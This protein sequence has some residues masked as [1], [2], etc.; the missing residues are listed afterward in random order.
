MIIKTNIGSFRVAVGNY[1]QCRIYFKDEEYFGLISEQKKTIL[2]FSPQPQ[3]NENGKYV[4]GINVEKQ[5]DE[6]KKEMKKKHHPKN[7]IFLR[8]IPQTTG[9]YELSER[10][11]H[12]KWSKIAH[13]MDKI[14]IYTGGE[15]NEDSGESEGFTTCWVVQ[16]G[17]ETEV[18]HI[19]KI[20][21][22]I[23]KRKEVYWDY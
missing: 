11:D 21:D 14:E 7:P 8:K 23:K 18:E 20:D 13:I 1:H 12:K 2:F 16:K 19:L 5:W 22:T 9:M 4:G 6:M 3:I 17:R 15:W 10:I